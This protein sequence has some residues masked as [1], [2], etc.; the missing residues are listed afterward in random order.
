MGGKIKINEFALEKE[1]RSFFFLASWH[2]G[3]LTWLPKERP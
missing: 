3:R 2:H 1:T